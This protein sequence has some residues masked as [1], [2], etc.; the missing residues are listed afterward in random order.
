MPRR[1][2]DMPCMA[3]INWPISSRRCTSMLA[4][5]SPSAICRARPITRRKGRTISRLISAVAA[6]PISRARAAASNISSE[7]ASCWARMSAFCNS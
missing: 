2:P 4:L 3:S 5:R 1:L 7:L 6:R